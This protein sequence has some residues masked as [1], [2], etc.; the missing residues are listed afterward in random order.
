METTCWGTPDVKVIYIKGGQIGYSDTE[1]GADNC[2]SIVSECA[3]A[4]TIGGKT[5][6]PSLMMGSLCSHCM[7]LLILTNV[8]VLCL[9]H[10]I[11]YLVIISHLNA[12]VQ[13]GL[14][15]LDDIVVPGLRK[16]ARHCEWDIEVHGNEADV[17]SEPE[18]DTDG[19]STPESPGPAVY[20][21]HKGS[22]HVLKVADP[23]QRNNDSKE[24]D[25]MPLPT[26]PLKFFSY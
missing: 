18:D 10:N 9:T 16:G 26:I 22:H 20:V 24:E 12:H 23:P 5:L 8:I 7:K 14:E 4:L 6:C 15:W 2:R 25:D 3:R 1:V 11:G 21:I 19:I 17:P 13:S